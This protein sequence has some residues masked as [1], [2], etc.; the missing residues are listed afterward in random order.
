VEGRAS[1]PSGRGEDARGSTS[2]NKKRH[3][4]FSVKVYPVTSVSSVVKIFVG[5]KSR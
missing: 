1:R 3:Y 2:N 4:C 5:W